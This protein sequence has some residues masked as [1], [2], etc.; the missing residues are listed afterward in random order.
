[1]ARR[2]EGSGIQARWVDELKKFG[3]RMKGLPASEL[4]HSDYLPSTGPGVEE[5]LVFKFG[6]NGRVAL[7]HSPEEPGK[8]TFL[9]VRGGKLIDRGVFSTSNEVHMDVLIDKLTAGADKGKVPIA[10]LLS[11]LERIP[12]SKRP[13]WT[14]LSSRLYVEQVERRAAEDKD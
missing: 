4:K 3:P 11:D 1:M 2:P 14:T 12:V 5:A 8:L 7:V 10:G 13:H 9:H 6:D